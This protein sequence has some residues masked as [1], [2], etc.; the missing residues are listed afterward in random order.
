MSFK[1][2]LSEQNDPGSQKCLLATETMQWLGIFI[3][4]RAVMAPR[5]EA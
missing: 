4:R 3:S 2:I 1:Y 5:L